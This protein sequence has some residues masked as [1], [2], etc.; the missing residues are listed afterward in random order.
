MNALQ[1]IYNDFGWKFD[2]FEQTSY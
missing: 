1:H 2:P